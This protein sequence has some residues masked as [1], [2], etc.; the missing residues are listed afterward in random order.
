MR[1]SSAT[2][3]II[4]RDKILL[5]SRDAGKGPVAKLDNALDY[6]KVRVIKRLQV[7]VLPGSLATTLLPHDSRIL[8]DL[9]HETMPGCATGVPSTLNSAARCTGSLAPGGVKWRQSLAGARGRL[10]QQGTSGGVSVG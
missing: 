8:R 10:W 9:L 4:R 5:V 2:A 6:E 7:R 3:T 1:N